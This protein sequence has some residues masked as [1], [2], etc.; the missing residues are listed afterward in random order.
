MITGNS[1][2]TADVDTVWIDRGRS[3]QDVFRA[4]IEKSIYYHGSSRF[5]CIALDHALDDGFITSHEHAKCIREIMK[6]T[7]TSMGTLS[8]YI[9]D[10]INELSGGIRSW[11]GN[12]TAIERYAHC[13]TIY[14]NWNNREDYIIPSEYRI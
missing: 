6:Y 8:G 2:A 1:L 5:M 13:R 12:T 14:E 10:R 9:E 11:M 3:P 7:G 4:I